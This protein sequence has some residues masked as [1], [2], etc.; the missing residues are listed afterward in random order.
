VNRSPWPWPRRGL[1]LVHG[2]RHEATNGGAR[3]N[4]V[5]S[6]TVGFDYVLDHQKRRLTI[7][8]SGSA[9]LAQI[10]ALLDRQAADGAWSYRLLHDARGASTAPSAT[11]VR[12]VAEHSR[13]LS[14]VHGPRGKVA[15]VTRAPALVGAMQIYAILAEEG[16]AVQVF[17]DRQEAEFWLNDGEAGTQA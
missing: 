14:L 16:S 3:T 12:T 10:L 5:C 2:G 6:R 8:R 13:R 4:V 17:W 11:E 1:R 7:V 9:D 15:F